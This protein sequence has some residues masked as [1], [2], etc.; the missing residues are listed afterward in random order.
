MLSKSTGQ[1]IR[2][3]VALHVLFHMENEDP[4]PDTVSQA[5]IEAAINFVEV[6]CQQTAYI[7]GRGDISNKYFTVLVYLP[8]TNI[9]ISGTASEASPMRHMF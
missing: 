6:C 2:V 4:L 5:A 7:A 1:I 3:S 9:G 8:P